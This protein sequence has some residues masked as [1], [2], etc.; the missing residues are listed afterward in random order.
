MV[1]PVLHVTPAP[2]APQLNVPRPRADE[3]PRGDRI[4]ISPDAREL[5]QRVLG[6]ARAARDVFFLRQTVEFSREVA[7]ASEGRD[8]PSAA[9]DEGPSAGPTVEAPQDRSEPPRF[10]PPVPPSPEPGARFDILA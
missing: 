2:S 8:V 6:R 4:E 9:K 10:E 5:A 7:A 1:G 3:E